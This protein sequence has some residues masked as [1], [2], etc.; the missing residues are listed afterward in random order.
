MKKEIRLTV[1]DE[2]K[3]FRAYV[4]LLLPLLKIRKREADVFAQLL[5]LNNQKKNIPN[6]DR[7]SIIFSTE[8]RKKIINNLGIK[9]SVL[10]NC[11]SELRKKKLIVNNTIPEKHQVIIDGDSLDMVY[12]LKLKDV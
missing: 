10:Q 12:K 4:E 2:Q 8:Y 11:F 6:A 1:E 3:L 5:Y 7:F 9:D